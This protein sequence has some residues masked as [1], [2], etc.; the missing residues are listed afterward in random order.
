MNNSETRKAI[1]K[2]YCPRF[3]QVAVEL[4]FITGQQLQR[5]ICMQVDDNLGGSPHRLLGQILFE[6]GWLS[7]RQIEVVLT[8]LLKRM[9]EEEISPR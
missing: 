7:P 8:T 1:S 9:R 5:A 2:K 4:K 6:L 3:G